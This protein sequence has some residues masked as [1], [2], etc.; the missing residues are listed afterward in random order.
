MRDHAGE[1]L[2]QDREV[3]LGWAWNWFE[4]VH[5]FRAGWPVHPWMASARN[6][7]RDELVLPIV[8]PIKGGA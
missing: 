5:A 7:K 3:R 1:Y 2:H 4:I 6:L 8:L